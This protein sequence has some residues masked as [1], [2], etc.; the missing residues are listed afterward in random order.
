MRKNERDGLRVFAVDEFGKLLRVGPMKNVECGDIAAEDFDQ[1]IV[2]A[3]RSFR[4]ECHFQHLF[5]VLQTALGHIFAAHDHL[6]ELFQNA[7][8]LLRRDVLDAR[9]FAADQL[10]FVVGEQLDHF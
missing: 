3:L 7:F 4:S 2:D 9:N 10:N 6:I 8:D 5:R 1:P